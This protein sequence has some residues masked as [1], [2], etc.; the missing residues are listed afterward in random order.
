MH[1]IKSALA[2][3]RPSAMHSSRSASVE[4]I[5]SSATTSSQ[6]AS[7]VVDLSLLSSLDKTSLS[8]SK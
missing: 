3:F 4:I 1:T 8:G 2:A 7:S 5:R 6:V